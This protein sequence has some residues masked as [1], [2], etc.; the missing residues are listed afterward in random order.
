M[1]GR[2]EGELPVFLS[3][4]NK[5]FS[6]EN[7]AVPYGGLPPQAAG[8][9]QVSPTPTSLSPR[10]F[11]HSFSIPVVFPP[12]CLLALIADNFRKMSSTFGQ[13]LPI[14]LSSVCAPTDV[15]AMLDNQ[16]SAST[17]SVIW[18]STSSLPVN[19]SNTDNERKFIMAFI[20]LSSYLLL[21]C[22]F[23]TGRMNCRRE[24]IPQKKKKIFSC[25]ILLYTVAV[26]ELRCAGEITPRPCSSTLL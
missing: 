21:P 20:T 19:W 8:A 11:A 16:V 25:W 2:A 9:A 18:T 7:P 10:C 13:M 23:G 12:S 24:E 6:Q 5:E 4:S 22:S 26:S 14:L 3:G 17:C 15:Q 1:A